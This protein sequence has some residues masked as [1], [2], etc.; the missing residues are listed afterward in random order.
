MF[1]SS[2]LSSMSL[3]DHI[4]ICCQ[5]YSKGVCD[6]LLSIPCGGLLALAGLI[7]SQRFKHRLHGVGLAGQSSTEHTESRPHRH[8]YLGIINNGTKGNPLAPSEE[9]HIPCARMCV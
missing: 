9:D 2:I 7:A 3:L 1:D 8:L 4:A 5:E 6:L